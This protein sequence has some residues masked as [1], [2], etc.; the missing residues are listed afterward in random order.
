MFMLNTSPATNGKGVVVN[1]V[2]VIT[3]ALAV[4]AAIVG[5]VVKIATP[6]LS[7]VNVRGCA[8]S[9]AL[10]VTMHFAKLPARS[11]ESIGPTVVPGLPTSIVNPIRAGLPGVVLV[12]VTA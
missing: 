5:A 11:A 1:A 6:F 9:L 4:P 2:K 12:M 10:T 7:R 8:G 3:L